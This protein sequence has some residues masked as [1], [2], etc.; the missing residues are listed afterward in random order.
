[1]RFK[2]HVLKESK[3]KDLVSCVG[4][5]TADE[6]YSSGDDHSILKWNLLSD[7]T[8]QVAQLPAENFPTDINWFPRGGGGK[9][10]SQSD[11]FV[12]T[13]T[14]GKFHLISRNGRIEK[15]VEAHRGAV[16]SGRW[17]F[18][19]SAMVTVGEDG[20]VKI[21]SR[22]GMLRSTL[23]QAGTPVYSVAWSP[24]SD[25]ILHT[26]GKQL[27][28]KPL[29]AAAKPIQWKAHDGVVLKVDWNSIN[30]IIISGGEDCKYKVW[31]SYGRLL[32]SSMLHE[33]PIT[34]I[35]W[36][37]NGQLFAVGSFNTLRL[38]DKTGWSYSLEKPNTGSIFNIAWSSDGTQLAGACGNGQVFFAHVI[39][40]RLEWK[41][42]EVTVTDKKSILV[43][44]VT[45][46][47]KESLDFR[48]RIIKTS[49]AFNHLVVATTSQCYIY[50]VRNWNTPM[51][52]DLKNGNITL[53][54]QT[55]KQFLLVDD[56]GLQ[57]YS[58]EGRLTCVPKYQ[59]LRSDVL[60]EQT[61]AISNDTLAIKDRKDEKA[62]HLFETQTG[63]LVGSGQP[64]QHMLEVMEIALSQC[65]STCDRQLAIIDKNRDLY[66]TPIKHIGPA[67]KLVKLGTMITTVAWNDKTN[68]LAAFQDGRF[69]VWYYPSAV[70][71]DQ[72][73][74]SKT[75]LE[76]DSSDFGKNPHIVSFL[77][78]H[79]TMRRAD[80]SPCSTIISPYP[81]MLHKYASESKWDDAIR[82]CRFVKD[83]VLWA[84]LATMAAHAKDLNTAET[85]YAAIDEADKVQYIN[86]IKEI[87]SQE[88]R[89]AAMALFCRQPQ[90][91]DTIL[92]QAGLIYRAIQM[93]I[94]LF[95]WDRALEL[96]VK[97]KTHVD[98]VLAYRQK[99]LNN[100][101]RIEKSKRFLQYTQGLEQLD[102]AEGQLQEETL[103]SK[104]HRTK[105]W[106]SLKCSQSRTGPKQIKKVL[107]ANRGEIACRVMKTA[108]KMGIRTVAVYSDA[109][110]N[111]MHVDMADEAFYIGAAASRESYLKMEK[112]IEV[113][114][115][116]GA[117]AIHPG[118]GF[119]S[120]KPE[121]AELCDKEGVIFIGP[122]PAAIRDMGIKSTSKQIM[123][124]AGVPIIDGYHGEDQ[125]DE[126]LKQE[127]DRIG[128]PVML[129]A[130]RGGGGKGMRVIMTPEEFD[131]ALESAKRESLKSFNDETMLVEKFVNTPR[132]VEVQVFA[133]TF[134]NTVYLFERDC[135][136]QRR[137]QKIIEE[138][139]APGM[140]S[141]VQRKLGE[142]AVRAARAVGYVGAGTVEFIMD[143]DQSFYFMEMNTRL[144]VEH[145][146]TEMITGQDLVEWQ[147]RVASGES[148]P[149]SQEDIRLTGHSFEARI[150]A[151]DPMSDFLPGAGPLLH[152]TTPH[153][154]DRIRV[155]TGVRQGDVVSVHYDPLIA[156]L[157]VWSENRGQAL[158]LLKESLQQYHIVGLSTNIGFLTSLCD[159]H[160]FKNGDV[161]TEFIKQHYQDLFPAKSLLHHETLAQA[162]VGLLLLEREEK[163]KQALECSDPYSEWNSS[164]NFRANCVAKRR[165]QLYDGDKKASVIVANK[166]D[167]SFTLE[168][169]GHYL[170]TKGKLRSENSRNCLTAS[171]DGR[172]FKS[173][174]VDQEGTINL[175]T[176]DDCHT[177]RRPVLS[178][179]KGGLSTVSQGSALA[180]M[181]GTI[182]KVLVEQGQHVEE[183]ET[184]VIME[185]MKMEVEW[186]IV[187]MKSYAY[188]W[189][190]NHMLDQVFCF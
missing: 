188:Q 39:E 153:P 145:P 9:K 167:G 177:L 143:R 65:G 50:S 84:C 55:E 83:T 16:L 134:G 141:E 136:V 75:L 67:E 87:P 148:L 175:F 64:L 2:T 23:V 132:H 71:V 46:N 151:E 171:I 34:S 42:F 15:S 11:L 173:W 3:H 113:A 41:N 107:I 123:S 6:L 38:C 92:L 44:D 103:S 12:L 165:I 139:P 20:Q 17:S 114:K 144:Q 70:Y 155:E 150:Y 133:D 4:W 35:S 47:I 79:C 31:D 178:F 121:F 127:A 100:F 19:G 21:W 152:L 58:Y 40:R 51:I 159:H 10:Q 158:S 142:A 1:M 52:F 183:G 68:M 88:G 112:I 186:C 187:V 106:R 124:D 86:H 109:D 78:N 189:L 26:S 98:T 81:S 99:Y 181:T 61:C 182:V 122:P 126:R 5:T 8:T 176:K 96:A 170:H 157:V 74:L 108:K 28:I 138:A 24:D 7:E 30:N 85:A 43:R 135:S 156:K 172:I 184:L 104:P 13:S 91:A 57:V 180:P 120:E 48:D 94:D 25:H 63:K 118:Y 105:L 54:V 179:I 49:L 116:S 29:Q 69:I 117:Q 154:S 161:H 66:I 53:I 125:S 128:Y 115:K 80:G 174:L 73:I 95:N 164:N 190:K 89:N 72:S 37:P 166:K 101:G 137:H 56:A 62:I 93:N 110:E 119:L 32:Y 76:K 162:C 130:V 90:E 149:L 168:I 27:V 147:L 18:D 22:S 59:N 102:L 36:A 129:K 131:A 45:N 82:L 140:S 14:D 185:A 111:S 160:H 60:N 169:D 33:Y 97:H 77:E 163:E 146:V